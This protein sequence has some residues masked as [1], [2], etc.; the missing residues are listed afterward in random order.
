MT[1]PT[2]KTERSHL[3]QPW[4]VQAAKLSVSSTILSCVI[5]VSAGYPGEHWP[6][7]AATIVMT[8][9]GASF[10][11]EIAILF[12][13]RRLRSYRNSVFRKH[14]L[15]WKETETQRRRVPVV[16]IAGSLMLSYAVAIWGAALYVFQWTAQLSNLPPMTNTVHSIGLIA[17]IAGALT[18]ATLIIVSFGMVALVDQLSDPAKP[19]PPVIRWIYNVAKFATAASQQPLP[20]FIFQ[21]SRAT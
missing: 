7:A 13:F 8:V 5:L 10:C 3:P 16:A 18:V 20:S 11:T 4:W 6:I 19:V 14:D 2:L 1:T 15:E 12:A 17:L 9:F 21:P